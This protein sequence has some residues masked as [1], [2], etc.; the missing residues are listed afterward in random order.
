V[1]GYGC[2]KTRR[3]KKRSCRC[4]KRFGGEASAITPT[5]RNPVSQRP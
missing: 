4:S 5:T 3:A 2:R 1:R